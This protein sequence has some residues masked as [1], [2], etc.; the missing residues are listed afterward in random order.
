[1]DWLGEQSR[2]IST[3]TQII[4][5]NSCEGSVFLDILSD[6]TKIVKIGNEAI[7]TWHFPLWRLQS[8][9][10]GAALFA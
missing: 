9:Y 7:I 2:T 5:P 10:A 6:W 1:M 8:I 4:M 3:F